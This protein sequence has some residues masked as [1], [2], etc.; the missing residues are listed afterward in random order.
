VQREVPGL[1]Y[2]W[3]VFEIGNNLKE[4]R[5]RRRVD[6]MDAENATKI[7]SKYLAGARD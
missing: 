6:L 3:L 4:A 2:S 7:R 5:L 1:R